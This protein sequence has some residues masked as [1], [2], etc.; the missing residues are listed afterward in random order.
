MATEE[1]YVRKYEAV[2]TS[3]INALY[4]RVLGQ[5]SIN[6]PVSEIVKFIDAETKGWGKF[7]GELEWHRDAKWLK[8]LKWKNINLS[9]PDT[10]DP[11]LMD[12]W[13]YSIEA[14]I[15]RLR[16]NTGFTRPAWYRAYMLRYKK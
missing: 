12:M 8:I 14:P 11:I 3:I 6:I 13:V 1:E 10:E 5:A 9:L 16:E 2:M 15:A 4:Y 7:G